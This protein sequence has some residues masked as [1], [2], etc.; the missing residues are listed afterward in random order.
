[1]KKT[2]LKIGILTSPFLFLLTGVVGQVKAEPYGWSPQVDFSNQ[3]PPKCTDAKPDKAPILLQPNHPVLPKKPKKGEVVL[4]W[5]RV[6]GATGNNVYYGLSKKNYI[7]SA[8]DIGDTDNFTIRYLPNRLFYFAV[9]AKRGCA[10]SAL[11]NEW[12]ARPAGGGYVSTASTL[13]AATVKKTVS[14][15]TKKT[16]LRETTV[17]LTAVPTNPPSVQGAQTGPSTEVNPPSDQ[18]TNYQQEYA[19]PQAPPAAKPV[20]PKK[21]GFL[22]TILSILFGR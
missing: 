1:M 12:A 9:Q 22:E 20:P 21:K 10:A 7:F 5:H 16:T 17:Q 13:G 14:S 19:P 3:G 15:T 8:P 4:Y 18:G 11:S 2:L 6:P